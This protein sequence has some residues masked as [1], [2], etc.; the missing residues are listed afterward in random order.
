MQ[1]DL[2]KLGADGMIWEAVAEGSSLS[3]ADLYR[4]RLMPEQAGCLYVFQMDARGALNV[5][6]PA[7]PGCKFG[8]GSNPVKGG[9]DAMVPPGG[10]L[11]LDD[12]IGVEHLFVVF[13]TDRWR[14]LE[15]RL[16]ASETAPPSTQPPIEQPLKLVL[17]GVAEV[18]PD[19]AELGKPDSEKA[20]P[21]FVAEQARALAVERWF[22]HVA[23][24]R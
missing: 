17:R 14:E 7:L 2:A 9:A 12:Q 13:T 3:S 11:R 20:P 22:F 10:K 1:V 18:V 16:A 19:R 4:L 21:R 15:E 24:P 6:F 23:A 5:L 8:E